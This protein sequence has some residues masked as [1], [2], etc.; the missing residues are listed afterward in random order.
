MDRQSCICMQFLFLSARTSKNSH[1]DLVAILKYS[2]Q[3]NPDETLTKSRS[4]I[5]GYYAASTFL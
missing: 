4:S 2:I 1:A 3:F 5:D